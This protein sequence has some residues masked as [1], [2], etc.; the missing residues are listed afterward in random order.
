MK[1]ASKEMCLFLTALDAGRFEKGIHIRRRGA[2]ADAGAGP[3]PV[4][5]VGES[6]TA[7]EGNKPVGGRHFRAPLLCCTCACPVR[8]GSA[9]NSNLPF[10]FA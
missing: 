1:R 9:E 6:I 2:A 8:L 7:I 4:E 3:G 10:S 5:M